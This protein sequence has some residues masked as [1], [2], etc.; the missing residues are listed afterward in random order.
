MLPP[1]ALGSL[2]PLPAGVGAWMSTREGGHSRAPW[3]GF[4]LGDHVGDAPL[5]VQANR[6]LLLEELLN[7]KNSMILLLNYSIGEKANQSFTP[8]KQRIIFLKT[9]SILILD[10]M[11][12]KA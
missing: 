6:Q 5:H 9:T 12:P 8:E 4:N 3:D 11:I 7:N 2:P 10:T 1:A